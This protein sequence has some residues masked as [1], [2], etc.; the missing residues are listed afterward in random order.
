MGTTY[1][2]INRCLR[3]DA[4]IEKEVPKINGYLSFVKKYNAT[5]QKRTY[6]DSWDGDG[7]KQLNR[8]H[9]KHQE[10]LLP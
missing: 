7:D 10:E 9:R 1:M 3:V 2:H 8:I 4:T 6:N 5:Q